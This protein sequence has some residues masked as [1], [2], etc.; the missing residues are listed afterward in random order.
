MENVSVDAPRAVERTD[1][2]TT[3][4]GRPI[5]RVYTRDHLSSFDY[6][7]DLGDPGA[8]PYTRGIHASG[9]RGKLWTMRQFAGFGTPEETNARYRQLL[10]AGGTGLSVAF[11]L[12]TLMGRDPDHP[13]SLGEVGKC[14]VNIASLADMETLFEGIPVGE[15]TTSMTINSP[16]SMLFAM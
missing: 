1:G 8:F 6:G 10:A 2:F 14:G 4:S 5:E 15:I 3:I 9:Y 12:P 7:R 16:A 13:L 11:D